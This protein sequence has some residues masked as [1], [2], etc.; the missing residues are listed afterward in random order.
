MD[1]EAADD[2]YDSEDSQDSG[3]GSGSTSSTEDRQGLPSTTKIFNREQ[4]FMLVYKN[5]KDFIKEH[6]TS[7]VGMS[8]FT[9]SAA[10]VKLY[11]AMKKV[12]ETEGS[13]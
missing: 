4:M 6:D 13:I 2:D 11:R 12:V 3:V 8:L 7:S 1:S 5:K 10:R 9:T